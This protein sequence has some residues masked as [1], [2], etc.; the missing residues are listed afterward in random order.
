MAT[1]VRAERPTSSKPGDKAIIS[2]DGTLTG[3]IGGSCAH[4][5]VVRSEVGI[6]LWWVVLLGVIV[7]LLPRTRLS[8]AAW[9][10]LLLFGIRYEAMALVDQMRKEAAGGSG[11]ILPEEIPILASPWQRLKQRLRAFSRGGLRAYLKVA[12]L[13]SAQLDLAMER[14]HRERQEIDTPLEAEDALRQ[15]VLQLRHWVPA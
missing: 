12:R 3:W 8:S 2:P 4:D 7:G 9:I 10:A 5:I 14:W 6:V 1:V 11:A 13:Q 15:R